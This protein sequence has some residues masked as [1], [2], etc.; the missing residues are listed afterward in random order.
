MHEA[1]YKGIVGYKSAMAQA[2]ILVER[3]LITPKEYR[4]IETKMCTEFRINCGSLYRENEWINTNSRGNMS[5]TKG[6]I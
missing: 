6:V 4:V 3:G 5:P 2:R 1:Y